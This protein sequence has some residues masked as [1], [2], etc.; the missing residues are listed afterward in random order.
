MK[1]PGQDS[2]S[3]LAAL[4]E[5]ELAGAAPDPAIAEITSLAA[6]LCNTPMAGIS[7]AMG[8]GLVFQARVGPGP[9]RLP[10]GN[11]VPCE[12]CIRGEG[13]YEI[14]DA[15]YH[16]DFRPDGIMIAGRAYRFYAGAPLTTPAGI[17]IGC[18]FVQDSMPHILN[19]KQKRAL[20]TLSRQVI[21]RF[22][23]NAHVRHME[24]DRGMR[25]RAE[26]ALTVERNFVSTVLDTVAALVAVFD[27]AGRIVR[28]NRACEQ[29][30]GYEFDT[31]VGRY[32]WEKLIPKEEVQEAIESFERLRAGRFPASFENRWQHRDG[33]LRRIAW[34][35]TALVDSQGQTSF[36]IA[37]GIDVTVQRQA[38]LTLR[39]SEARY[40]QL[41]EGSLGMV[42]TH[43]L[44][45]TLLS[46]NAH[47]AESLGRTNDEMVGNDLR[48]FM[49]ERFREAFGSYLRQ[50]R[51]TGEAQGRLQ[52]CH[53][54]GDIRVIAYRNKL[55]EVPGTPSY[56][57]GF[58]VDISEQVRAEEKL[59]ALIHQS[60]SILESVGDGI[61]GVDLEGRV[62]VI[63]PAAAQ[64]LGYRPNELLGRNLHQLILHTRADGK[65][66]PEAESAIMASIGNGAGGQESARVSSEIF[67][68]KDGS[69]FPVEYVAR[70]QIDAR[71]DKPGSP[72]DAAGSRR[73]PGAIGVVVAFTD[74]TER[75]ALD[76]MKDEFISTVSHEL[77]TPLTSLRAALGLVTGGAL[78]TRPEKM[79]QMLDIAIG[80]TDRLIKLVNDILDIERIGS[81][82]SELHSAHLQAQLLLERAAGLQHAALLK[83][84]V[85]LNIEGNGV[86]VWADPDRVL[87]ALANLISN[88]IKFSS[89]GGEIRIS[90]RLLD[91]HEAQFDVADDGRGIPP[92]KLE[93]IFE[94]F[95]QVDASD[96]RVMGGTGLGLTICRSIIT[97]HGG[98]I[99]A[100]SPPGQ[101][102]TF[103]FTLPT[104]PSGHLR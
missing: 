21:N 92:D 16:E 45:G 3:R 35:A 62:T 33:S 9:A 43:D 23:L 44:H 60:N 24:R 39:E 86:Q 98:R 97:Q 76:R 100:T 104:H 5:Y 26:Q 91:Q 61:Y 1:I 54:D 13:V 29:V 6:E 14:T 31:L 32:L 48:S 11:R 47:S 79:R 10:R 103:H 73:K 84:G 2:A 88:A 7:L 78:Q 70:P 52:L 50:I 96:S 40:R 18:L 58:G 46:V 42:C 66:Y 68:R 87:Q 71:T 41:V 53:R 19:E 4:E 59:R 25:A 64:M 81:G 49:P 67:W 102:A 15:R 94:R 82:N 83:A 63:N 36:I 90:A 72:T 28:F 55:I 38:E 75:R 101:G 22:E 57:L 99:W 69:S 30:S 37:T 56:V 89:P 85:R 34:S 17:T 80:N 51:Q 95:Q 20:G 77:R 93:H 12:K 65:P 74:T 8:D 27:T